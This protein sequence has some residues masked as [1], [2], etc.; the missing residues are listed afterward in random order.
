MIDNPITWIVLTIIVFCG[1][2]RWLLNYVNSKQK[3]RPPQM[4]KDED[5]VFFD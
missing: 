1:L 2:G 4:E 3:P 5:L